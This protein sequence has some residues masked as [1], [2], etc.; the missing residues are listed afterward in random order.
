[1]MIALY[2]YDCCGNISQYLDGWREQNR[3]LAVIISFLG[4]FSTTLYILCQIFKN[5]EVP[6]VY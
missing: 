6:L 2:V 1:M 3:D 4:M 5:K